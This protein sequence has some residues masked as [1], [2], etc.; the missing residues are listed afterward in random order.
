MLRH[1]MKPA[2]ICLD[3]NSIAPFRERELRV[4]FYTKALILER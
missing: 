1:R 3:N 2:I 4:R